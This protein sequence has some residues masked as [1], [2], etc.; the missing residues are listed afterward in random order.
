[1]SDP[2]HDL[3]RWLGEKLAPRG[4]KSRAA[5]ATELTPDKITRSIELDDPDPK[6]RRSIQIQEIEALAR[7]LGELPPGYEG[8]TRWLEPIAEGREEPPVFSTPK[9]NASF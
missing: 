4:M 7:F 5:A 6:K 8:M 3:K 1:M 2:Q 9:P